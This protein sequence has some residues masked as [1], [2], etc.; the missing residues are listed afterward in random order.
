MRDLYASA[1]ETSNILTLH[2]SLQQL[3]QIMEQGTTTAQQN[4]A[5]AQQEI[6]LPE[7]DLSHSL[8]LENKYNKSR[9]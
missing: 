9:L 4:A 3:A 8:E 7:L 5:Q 6:L 2:T 1:C